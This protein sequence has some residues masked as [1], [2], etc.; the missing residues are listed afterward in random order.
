MS[1]GSKNYILSDPDIRGS[2]IHGPHILAVHKMLPAS[3]LVALFFAY[4][5]FFFFHDFWHVCEHIRGFS[6]DFW[7]SLINHELL[8]TYPPFPIETMPRHSLI[9]H[10]A[11]FRNVPPANVG[12]WQ[13][14][15][16]WYF[17]KMWM[18]MTNLAG[19]VRSVTRTSWFDFGS[20]LNPDPAFQWDTKHELFTVQ[21]CG[22]MCSTAYR[23]SWI[24]YSMYIPFL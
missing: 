9:R 22:G 21:P 8:G 6:W 20:G 13:Y 3:P 5:Q 7:S 19:W 16:A 2:A 4:S 17:K 1:D 14:W 18:V 11:F 12:V 15:M 10:A 24:L 23:S